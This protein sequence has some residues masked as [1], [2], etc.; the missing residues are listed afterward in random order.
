MKYR[1]PDY[2]VLDHTADLAIEVRAKTPGDLFGDAVLAMFS[3]MVEGELPGGTRDLAVRAEGHDA[4]D[5]LVR[6]LTE[7]LALMEDEGLL[8]GGF[9]DLLVEEHRATGIARVVGW[10]EAGVRLAREIKAVTYHGIEV[11][12]EPGDCCCR[13]VFDL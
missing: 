2:T 10:K 8:V 3:E 1:R 6:W 4:E 13:V 12:L 7:L 11:R 5:L 9:R